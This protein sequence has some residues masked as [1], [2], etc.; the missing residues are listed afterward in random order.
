MENVYIINSHPIFSENAVCLSTK[1]NIPIIKDLEPKDGDVY[2]VF[3]GHEIAPQLLDIQDRIKI[4]Y[5]LFNS[6][7]IE[8]PFFKNKYYIE[9]LKNNVLIDYNHLTSKYL[10]DTFNIKTYSFFFFEFFGLELETKLEKEID[11]FFTGSMN[12]NRE[13]LKKKLLEEFPNKNIVFDFDWS[14]K[15]S[16]ELKEVLQKS[17]YVINVPYYAN[18]TLETHRINSALACGC[19]VVSLYSNDKNANTYYEDYIHFTDDIVEWFKVEHHK[20]LKTYNDLVKDLSQKLLPH[21]LHV[22]QKI[23]NEFNIY[24]NKKEENNGS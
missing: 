21:N 6:E 3:G 12:K 20:E 22:I 11:I 7:Q 1:L 16:M 2:V 17:K 8:S 18:N 15:T 19:E 23:K 5:I 9:L 24:V 10:K 13:E 14:Y 4:V